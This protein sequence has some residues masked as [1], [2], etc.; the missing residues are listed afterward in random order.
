M[1]PTA[2]KN[3]IGANVLISVIFSLDANDTFE[4]PLSYCIES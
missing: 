4:S 2:A 3:M 1:M